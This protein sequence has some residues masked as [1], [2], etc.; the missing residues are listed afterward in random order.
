MS[1][2]ELQAVT[3]AFGYSGHYIT[4]RLLAQGV[5]VR[6]LTNSAQRANPFGEALEVHPYHF[7]QPELLIESLRGVSVLYNTYWVRYDTRYATQQQAVK[8]SRVLFD[9]ARRAGVQRVVH[10]S[11]LNPQRDSP[12]QYFRYKAELEDALI[13][14][15]LSHAILRPAILF[16]G[17]DTLLNNIAWALRHL[18]V[19]GIFGDGRYCLQPIYVDDL[20]ALAVEQGALRDNAVIDAIGPETFAFREL[21]RIISEAIGVHRLLISVPPLAGYLATSLIGRALGD[22]MLTREE[23][24]GLMQGLLFSPSPPSGHTKLTAWVQQHAPTL[25]KQYSSELARRRKKT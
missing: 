19:F 22:V 25:G 16:G 11:I 15:G 17:Q 20:A 4:A 24:G 12:Y 10:V 3:G 5:R 1:A 18:P 2:T 8:N 21:V 7:D 13:A 6:T 14:S 9:A 23:I